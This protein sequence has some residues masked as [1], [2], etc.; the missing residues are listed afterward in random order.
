MEDGYIC[1]PR[2]LST[3]PHVMGHLVKITIIYHG[4]SEHV[5][6]TCSKIGLFEEKNIRVVAVLYLSN[7]LNRS[8]YRDFF[9]CAH[10]CMCYR[11]IQVPWLF[12]EIPGYKNRRK[13]Q[14]Y[15]TGRE[16]QGLLFRQLVSG[17]FIQ[18]RT[19]FL[20]VEIEIFR[21]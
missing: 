15:S 7:A 14:G 9:I 21:A 5:A 17:L 19:I 11:L 2:Q 3:D 1:L 4:N 6:H 20:V 13:T 8:K 12:T 10:L 16:G 18:T